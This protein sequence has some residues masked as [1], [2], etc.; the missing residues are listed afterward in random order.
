M[1]SWGWCPSSL[2]R[3]R[4]RSRRPRWPSPPVRPRRR[5]APV[6]QCRTRPTRET[7]ARLLGRRQSA[8]GLARWLHRHS[9]T[10]R[11]AMSSETSCREASARR[12]RAGAARAD[13][14]GRRP[15][16]LA[17]LRGHGGRRDALPPW[18]PAR[19]CSTCASSVPKASASAR[20]STAS[21]MRGARARCHHGATPVGS[22]SGWTSSLS[23]AS[24]ASI[25]ATLR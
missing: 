16:R 11:P 1:G 14:S 2:R 4:L 7:S 25:S 10:I 6:R 15:G 9:I 13:F 8:W 17:A 5:A 3:S 22:A 18:S 19:Q 23:A 21:G 24:S 20:R 12:S